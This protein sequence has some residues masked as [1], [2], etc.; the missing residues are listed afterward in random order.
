MTGVSTA[1]SYSALLTGFTAAQTRLNT[2]QQQISS[3]ELA[4]T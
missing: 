1:N 4:A 2:A 3:G